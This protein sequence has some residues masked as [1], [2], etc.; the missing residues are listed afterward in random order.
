MSEARDS[1]TIKPDDGGSARVF[2]EENRI[3]IDVQ[4]ALGPMSSPLPMTLADAENL[5]RSIGKVCAVLR[6]KMAKAI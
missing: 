6:G 5:Q 2:V 1:Y 3:C 4:S